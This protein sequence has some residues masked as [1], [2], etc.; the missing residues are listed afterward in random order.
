M[1]NQAL[2]DTATAIADRKQQITQLENEIRDLERKQHRQK[3]MI[4]KFN[5]IK[6]DLQS[7]AEDLVELCGADYVTDELANIT[8]PVS[9]SVIANK[10]VNECT[11]ET[12]PIPTEQVMQEL[13]GPSEESQ[14]LVLEHMKP[15]EIQ[16][17]ALEGH[18]TNKMAGIALAK[19]LAESAKE[20]EK[21]I[22][23]CKIR[24][25]IKRQELLKSDQKIN[26]READVQFAFSNTNRNRE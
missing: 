13:D 2:L 20:L 1:L 10:V 22:E 25:Q 21:T 3:V 11:A 24:E 12:V 16:Q 23:E 7:V 26:P 5:C 14:L 18:I 6:Q 4:D 19:Q 15:E 8:L 9:K 17:L